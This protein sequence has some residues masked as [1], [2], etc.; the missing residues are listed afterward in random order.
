MSLKE[1]IQT[2]HMLALREGNKI[3]R[4]VLGVLLSDID[5]EGKNSVS[6]DEQ[7]MKVTKKLVEDNILSK[8]ENENVYLTCYLPQ[9]LSDEELEKHIGYVSA[10]AP[11]LTKPTMGEIMKYLKEEFPG[12]YDGKKA[13][14]IIRKYI[15]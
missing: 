8:T 10:G 1:R 4:N 12:R 5:R 15:S 6:T 3:K 11:G 9:M 14:E 2:D 7:V 13:S